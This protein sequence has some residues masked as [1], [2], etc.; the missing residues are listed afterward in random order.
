MVRTKTS[1][2]KTKTKDMSQLKKWSTA[3]YKLMV[4][5][6]QNRLLPA[7]SP[8]IDRLLEKII[9]S[10]VECVTYIHLDDE[11]HI[12][13]I[14]Y[15]KHDFFKQCDGNM[16]FEI[17]QTLFKAFQLVGWEY[18]FTHTT[19]G[20]D[21]L[22]DNIEQG[23]ILHDDHEHYHHS[24]DLKQYDDMDQGEI[25]SML[26]YQESDDYF[27]SNL[28]P[29][30]LKTWRKDML[31]QNVSPEARN[32]REAHEQRMLLLESDMH[33]DRMQ[34]YDAP[35]EKLFT[36]ADRNFKDND[37]DFVDDFRNLHL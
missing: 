8:K 19:M 24:D 29:A 32:R 11:H 36:V 10:L 4:M 25:H 1:R 37:D 5:Y 17:N 26:D 13:I 30:S 20:I 15:N 33:A 21:E 35:L 28:S 27:M 2:S 16:F 9:K 18:G 12:F 6:S 14:Y 22:M 3:F 7:D 31:N 23:V 34:R